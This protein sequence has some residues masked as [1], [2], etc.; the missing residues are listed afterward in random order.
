MVG[1]IGVITIG[2]QN[3]GF[4]NKRI[5]LEKKTGNFVTLYY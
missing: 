2:S 3:Q 1:Y 4:S 5:Q